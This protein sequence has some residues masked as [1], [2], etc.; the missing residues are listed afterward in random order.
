M[1]S[2]YINKQLNLEDVINKSIKHSDT[3]VTIHVETKPTEPNRPS[4]GNRVEFFISDMW[5]PYRD[6]A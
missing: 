4:S 5:E 1:H 3:L 6:I 2:N